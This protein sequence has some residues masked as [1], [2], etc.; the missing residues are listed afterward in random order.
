MCIA[1]KKFTCSISNNKKSFYRCFN[2]RYSKVGY[3]A[4]DEVIVKL[5]ATKCLPVFIYGLDACPVSTT[6]IRTLD[7]VMTRTF[8]KVFRTSSV[9]IVNECQLMFNFRKVSDVIVTRKIRFLQRYTGCDNIFC[10]LFAVNATKELIFL[11]N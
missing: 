4:S 10:G 9:D 3:I 2:S 7:F 8:M 11:T 1:A 5:I 6:D